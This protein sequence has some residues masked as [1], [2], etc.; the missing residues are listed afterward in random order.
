MIEKALTERL[1]SVRAQKDSASSTD[2]PAEG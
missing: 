2:F 1:A